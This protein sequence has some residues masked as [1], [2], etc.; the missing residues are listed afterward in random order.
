MVIQR[1]QSLMLLIATIVMV[2]FTFMS[3]G[4]IQY[5]DYILNFTAIGFNVENSDINNTPI[6]GFVAYTWPLFVVSF[7]SFI[8]PLITLFL[9]KNLQLQ[10][11]LCLIEIL[12]LMA[13]IITCVLYGY[14]TF[15]EGLI[16]WTII[17]GAP[18][19][20]ICA[21]VMA[22]Y[23]ISADLKLLRSVDRIR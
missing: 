15:E 2:V 12:F 20:A 17:T 19:I 1:W 11:K 21:V 23:R 5:Q 3:L 18:I 7:L 8:M 13:V 16:S 4:H 22:Y 6:S 9:Y 14:K 10:K